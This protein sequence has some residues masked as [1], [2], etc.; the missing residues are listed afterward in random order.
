MVFDLIH[1]SNVNKEEEIY[2][3]ENAK[4]YK[5][6][7]NLLK[8]LG[9]SFMLTKNPKETDGEASLKEIFTKDP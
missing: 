9:A 8:V 2:S 7:L 1:D 5:D 4:V 3:F 6:N